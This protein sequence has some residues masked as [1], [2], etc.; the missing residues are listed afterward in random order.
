MSSTLTR[1]SLKVETVFYGLLIGL[2]LKGVLDAT[3]HKVF[4]KAV[5][6]QDLAKGIGTPTF[7]QLL[8]FVVT[9]IRFVLGAYRVHDELEVHCEEPEPWVVA[10]SFVGTLVL[11]V[12]FYF[13]GL[14]VG[15]ASLFYAT[16]V[17]LHCWDLSWFILPA[18]FS[19]HLSNALKSACR[20]FLVIDAFTIPL[21][22]LVLIYGAGNVSII[23]GSLMLLIAIFDF[24]WLRHFY[25]PPVE[26]AN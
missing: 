21:L 12:I 7:L 23:G 5:S 1:S 16:F 26:M 19:D 18:I 3:Y 20:R 17:L 2:A 13:A 11:F 4:E 10:Y 22:I 24:L 8:V 25:F 15:S 9:L 14:S 6:W